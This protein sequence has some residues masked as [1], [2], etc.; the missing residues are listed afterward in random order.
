MLTLNTNDYVRYGTNGICKVL[1]REWKSN[2]YHG[3]KREYYVLQPVK[4]DGITLY[5]PADNDALL[6]KMAPVLT[7]DKIDELILSVKDEQ[8]PWILDRTARNTYFQSVLRA[9][10]FRDL[11]VLIRSIYLKR[12]ELQREQ[13][14]LSFTDENALKD[15][16]TLVR[17]DFAFSLNIP[18]A[19]VGPYIRAVL[20]IPS[21]VQSGTGK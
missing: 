16:E 12:Q 20:G 15:A 3:T 9:G 13:K 10:E 6:A 19:E 11:L 18:E 4:G 5:V 1:G 8:T 7:Q 17:K 14:K 2:A 21:D